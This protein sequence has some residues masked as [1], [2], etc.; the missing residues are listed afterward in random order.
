MSPPVRTDTAINDS[1]PR[2]AVAPVA[3][4]ARTITGVFVCMGYLHGKDIAP[5][6]RSPVQE[7]KN[8]LLLL[9]EFRKAGCLA[10]YL[11]RRILNLEEGL[12]FN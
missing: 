12:N 11:S 7:R 8:D 10:S 4:V 6:L 2:K 9:I 1:I 3:T 5:I